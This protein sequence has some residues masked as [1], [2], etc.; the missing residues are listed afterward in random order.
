MKELLFGLLMTSA[1]FC[2]AIAVTPSQDQIDRKI[3]S[4]ELRV[5]AIYDQIHQAS[6][7]QGKRWMERG[8]MYR[9]EALRNHLSKETGREIWTD[10]EL[11][12]FA[13]FGRAMALRHKSEVRNSAKEWFANIKGK[14]QCD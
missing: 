8:T 3:I 1:L 13:E 11:D 6:I 14:D 7:G 5:R 10:E 2:L 12:Q 9:R 4:D